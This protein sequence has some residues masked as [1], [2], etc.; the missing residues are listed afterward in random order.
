MAVLSTSYAVFLGFC[1]DVFDLRWRHK[2]WLPAVATIPLLVAYQGV[3]HIV[4]PSPLRSLFGYTLELGI[5]YYFYMTA[6]TIFCTNAINIYAG[7]NGLEVG[8]SLII[9][10]SIFIHNSIEIFHDQEIKMIPYSNE[11]YI[12]QHKFSLMLVTLY[13]FV[14]LALYHFNK[15][16]SKVFVGDTFVYWSGMVFAVLGILG[17]F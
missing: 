6:M 12:H 15:Y 10:V 8:Q 1:D 5:F 11:S 17:H 4:L 9:A 14:T 7:I 2:L 13:I 16:P 3:T